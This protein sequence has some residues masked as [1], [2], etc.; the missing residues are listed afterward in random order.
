MS[1]ITQICRLVQAAKGRY[2]AAWVAHGRCL[3]HCRSTG[4]SSS[5]QALSVSYLEV[6]IQLGLAHTNEL[7]Y[8]YRRRWVEHIEI[9]GIDGAYDDAFVRVEHLFVSTVG[10]SR[11]EDS[12]MSNS[13]G[14]WQAG[15]GQVAVVLKR[16][17]TGEVEMIWISGRDSW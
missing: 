13:M 2:L 17:L 15:K 8:S 7:F 12:T 4:R 3:H 10:R 5:S 9:G 11:A 16:A 6:V 1:S 14:G